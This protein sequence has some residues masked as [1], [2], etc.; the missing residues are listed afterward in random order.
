MRK[1]NLITALIEALN[2][3]WK[4]KNESHSQLSPQKKG[5]GGRTPSF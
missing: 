4:G 3:K 5:G 2:K 1:I